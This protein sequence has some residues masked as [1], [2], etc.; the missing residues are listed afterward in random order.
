MNVHR[1]QRPRAHTK[2]VATVGPA[3]RSPM[4]LSALID[5]GVDVFRL[6]MAHG[7]IDQHEEVL[8]TI[9]RLSA[10]KH[11]PIGVLVDLAG[12]KI[13]L[14]EIPGGS[15]ECAIGEKFTFTHD[16]ESTDPRRLTTTYALL[17]SEL[18]VGDRVMLA[19]G[20]VTM[21]VEEKTR[22]GARCRCTQG[23]LLRSRQGVNLPGVKVS[24]PAMSD[25]DKE[26]AV[27]AATHGIDYVSLSF[28]RSPKEVL[29]LKWLLG[30][31]RSQARVIAKIE[32]QEA[33]DHLE[34]IIAAADG[35]MV[36]RGD[37]GV[38]IDVARMP[39]VQKQIIAA[40]QRHQKP[41]IV[42]TQMLDS[43]QRSSRPTRAEVTDV[44]NAI[45][46]GCDA[47]MLSGETAVG[48]FPT[49]AVEM[50]NRVA[51]ATEPLFEA[52]P[53]PPVSDVLPD[54]L[55]PITYA[56]VQGAAHIAKQVNARMLIVVSHSG[57]TALSMSKFRS[58]VPIVG[59]SNREATLRQMCL[60]W[61]VVP[62]ADAPT[63]DSIA[64]IEYVEQWG[65]ANGSLNAG[66]HVV[67][68]AGIGL[69]SKGHNMVRVH[70]VGQAAG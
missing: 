14:G 2:I 5:A 64:L 61:G 65:L 45:L 36:A 3:S 50:M 55:Q 28:V 38:E 46:D 67:L 32:K 21:L 17:I 31:Q 49:A 42:A 25:E 59:V 39:V 57:I 19:D 43:M 6:N 47:C 69:A 22:D 10:E 51:M 33:L 24:L 37:L 52:R 66:D 54:G 56:V 29:E 41:V 16:D 68:V 18:S 70:T 8:T 30:Y 40:C 20:T 1:L 27:W 58:L 7:E 9:R 60:V 35:V 26:H 63:T 13:R 11:H 44:A 62:L 34:E 53:A 4:M 48:D 23:G 15:V 12:P